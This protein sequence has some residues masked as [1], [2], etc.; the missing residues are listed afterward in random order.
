MEVE[1]IKALLEGK[2]LLSADQMPSIYAVGPFISSSLL[3]SDEEVVEDKEE[4][5]KW[6]DL[7]PASSVLF[8]SFGSVGT[9]SNDQV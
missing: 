2:V 8:V 5:L 1:Q 7:Q 3:A 6:L 4:C 9:L